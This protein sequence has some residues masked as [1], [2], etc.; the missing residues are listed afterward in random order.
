MTEKYRDREIETP[1]QREDEG[2]KEGGEKEKE[3]GRKRGREKEGGREGRR[4]A[5]AV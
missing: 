2:D 5:C 1:I 3:G 4:I